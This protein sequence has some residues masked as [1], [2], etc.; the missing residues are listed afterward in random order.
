MLLQARRDHRSW[1]LGDRCG[2]IRFGP[3]GRVRDSRRDAKRRA[4]FAAL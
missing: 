2:N 3:G 4:L 1:Q